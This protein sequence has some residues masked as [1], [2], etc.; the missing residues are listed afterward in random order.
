MRYSEKSLGALLIFGVVTL[1]FQ[2]PYYHIII[3]LTHARKN[4]L[5][6]AS[7]SPKM[8]LNVVTFGITSAAPLF[9]LAILT[10]NPLHSERCVIS[11]KLLRKRQLLF[12]VN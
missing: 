3:I 1:G 2:Y 11:T 5:R 9:F 8:F 4:T 7:S 10:H 6:C 12:P